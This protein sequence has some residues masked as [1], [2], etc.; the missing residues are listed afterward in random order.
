MIK[1]IVFVILL[2]L[3]S[4]IAYFIGYRD[5]STV[6]M[7]WYVKPWPPAVPLT[8][9]YTKDVVQLP[10]GIMS[11]ASDCWAFPD[12]KI[13]PAQIR[14]SRILNREGRNDLDSTSR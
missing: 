9:V 7:L 10:S 13:T 2:A 3:A 11:G 5:G 1:N 4:G 8:I 6:P 12:N 14:G